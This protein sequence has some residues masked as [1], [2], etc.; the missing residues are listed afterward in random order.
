MLFFV[1]AC[2]PTVCPEGFEAGADG[3]CYLQAQD[4]S[5]PDQPEP[6][7]QPGEPPSAEQAQALLQGIAEAGLPNSHQVLSCQ[8]DWFEHAEPECPGGDALGWTSGGCTTS[9]G[10]YFLGKTG[11]VAFHE[12][13]GSSYSGL[14][15]AVIEAPTG[16]LRVGGELIWSFTP[17]EHGYAL[18]AWVNGDFIEDPPTFAWMGQG[19]GNGLVWSS[20]DEEQMWLEGGVGH[21]LGSLYF[22]EVSLD[23]QGCLRGTTWVQ[24]SG[25]DPW[26]ELQMDCDC[27]SSE[28]G[29]ICAPE[30]G[31]SALGTWEALEVWPDIPVMGEP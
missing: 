24:V 15:G 5:T 8:Q 18:E 20:T 29:E 4:S 23:R 31:R 30:L 17:A 25:F 2:A 11:V 13:I 22:D 12:D 3:N 7:W 19:R 16:S 1:L 27:A 28:L 10:V 26:V 21:Q 6:G 14:A 9:Q